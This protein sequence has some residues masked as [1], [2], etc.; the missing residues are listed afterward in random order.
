MPAPTQ[1]PQPEEV[2]V[3]ADALMKD[4]QFKDVSDQIKYTKPERNRSKT[5]PQ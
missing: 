3:E 1:L 4:E 2:K 5:R